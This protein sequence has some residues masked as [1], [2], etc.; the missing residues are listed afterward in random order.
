[1]NQTAPT[2]GNPAVTIINDGPAQ[3]HKL[4]EILQ[5]FADGVTNKYKQATTIGEIQQLSKIQNALEHIQLSVGHLR[6]QL[7]AGLTVDLSNYNDRL[8]AQLDKLNG[9]VKLINN[10]NQ[11]IEIATEV[12]EIA[13]GIMKM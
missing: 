5:A 11:L 6:T 12:A 3:L 1:M 2:P 4:S 7:L 13:A 9:I 10:I 8:Q